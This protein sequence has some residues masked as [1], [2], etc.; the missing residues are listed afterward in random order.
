[1]DAECFLSGAPDL[2]GNKIEGESEGLGGGVNRVAVGKHM[3][4]LE[5]N[6]PRLTYSR[7][8]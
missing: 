8:P 5:G 7:L 2:G 6:S 3:Y 4:F 1:M